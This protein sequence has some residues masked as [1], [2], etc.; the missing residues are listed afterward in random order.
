MLRKRFVLYL[1]LVIV[2]VATA[3][4]FA[5][6]ASAQPVNDH[7]SA[8]KVIVNVPY[9]DSLDITFATTD[10]TDPHYVA[11]C[12]TTLNPLNSVWYKYTP[13]TSGTITINTFGSAFDTILGAYTGTDVSGFV[14]VACNDNAP[15]E[16]FTLQSQISFHATAGVQ[17]AIMVAS[18][19]GKAGDSTLALNFFLR[20]ANDDFGS[21]TVIT[22][23]P[24]AASGYDY[25]ATSQGTDPLPPCKTNENPPFNTLWFRY[26]PSTSGTVTVD[27]TG[28]T[29]DT[30]LSAWTGSPGAFASVLN[31]C[32]NDSGGTFQSQISF[33]GT[34]NTTYYLMISAAGGDLGTLTFHLNGPTPVIPPPKKR[35]GQIT[36]Q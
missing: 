7:F 23:V 34:A 19:D 25:E 6:T 15:T 36:S 4:I 24:F 1:K 26:T 29:Y 12:P 13:P 22:T 27:T 14:Q 20:P 5:S 35:S 21:A 2:G 16:D 31:G 28:S 33:S 10:T 30:V 32:N 9:T 3:I 17:Y 18:S 11:P 8:A